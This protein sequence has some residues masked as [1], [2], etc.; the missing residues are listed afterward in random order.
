MIKK[1]LSK[2]GIT[3]TRPP[4][5]SKVAEIKM[6]YIIDGGNSYVNVETAWGPSGSVYVPSLFLAIA[7]GAIDEKIIT[8]FNEK[9]VTYLQ[10]KQPGLK[11]NQTLQSSI[12]LI[13]GFKRAFSMALFSSK[14]ISNCRQLKF[15]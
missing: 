11:M 10:M 1:L 14:P 4:K 7:N 15:R 6:E 9:T 5:K 3:L 8:I 2:L 12:F 13:P